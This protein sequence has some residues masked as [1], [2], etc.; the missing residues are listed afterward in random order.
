MHCLPDVLQATPEH[1]DDGSVY[2]AMHS[3]AVRLPR[4]AIAYKVEAELGVW[5]VVG[6]K[7]CEPVDLPAL[8][9]RSDQ[10]LPL[11]RRRGRFVRTWEFTVA[12]AVR[13][14]GDHY[15]QGLFVG[16][17]LGEQEPLWR[18]S[19]QAQPF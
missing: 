10:Y 4:C 11:R 1:I 18:F 7:I 14:D 2:V 3:S 6:G 15:F 5:V 16:I 19:V 8:R 12:K 13:N 17:A 9:E